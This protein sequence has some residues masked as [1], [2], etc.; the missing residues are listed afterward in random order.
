[1]YVRFAIKTPQ[2]HR[3]GKRYASCRRT[4][5]DSVSCGGGTTVSVCSDQTATARRNRVPNSGTCRRSVRWDAGAVKFRVVCA[6]AYKLSPSSR[7]RAI[8]ISFCTALPMAT[9]S[10]RRRQKST[11]RS[12]AEDLFFFFRPPAKYL[13]GRMPPHPSCFCPPLSPPSELVQGVAM[14]T[15]AV[16]PFRSFVQTP[17]FSVSPSS[18]SLQRI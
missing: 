5:G 2:A 6:Q 7:S 11:A 9:S 14:S 8:S 16:T 4:G 17:V 10:A 15:A 1:M 13:L 3:I 18:S 12:L